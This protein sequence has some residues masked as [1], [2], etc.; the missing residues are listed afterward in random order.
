VDNAYNSANNGAAWISRYVLL[1]TV[2]T[3]KEI[4][5][6]LLLIILV[7]IIIKIMDHY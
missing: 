5:E 7:N 3:R 2:F 6:E 1:G 4:W